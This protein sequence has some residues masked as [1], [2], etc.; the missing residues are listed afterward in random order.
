MKILGILL[1]WLMLFWLCWPLAVIGL[2]LWPVVWIASIP[3]RIVSTAVRA[4][5]ALLKNILMLPARLVALPF[6]S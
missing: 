4:V 5:L 1:L 3:F 6:R 2:V